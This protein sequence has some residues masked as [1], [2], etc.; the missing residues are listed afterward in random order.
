RVEGADTRRPRLSDLRESGE[1]EQE[2][3]EVMFL[4][5]D[6]A[7][8]RVPVLKAMM[9]LEKHRY[10]PTCDLPVIFDKAKHTFTPDVARKK[11]ESV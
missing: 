8:T 5:S 6:E 2:A 4:W 3:D 7:N 11:G 10:G 9:S 1:I